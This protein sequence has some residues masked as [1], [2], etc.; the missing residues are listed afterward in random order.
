MAEGS[1]DVEATALLTT[2]LNVDSQPDIAEFCC[3]STELTPEATVAFGGMPVI[4]PFEFVMV[5]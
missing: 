2:V 4:I 3:D 1:S 5:V